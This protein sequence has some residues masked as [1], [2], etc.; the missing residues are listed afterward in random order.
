MNRRERDVLIAQL[1]AA[2]TQIDAT[3]AVLGVPLEGEEPAESGKCQH[4][5]DK[6]IDLSTFGDEKY[7]CGE[8]GIESTTNPIPTEG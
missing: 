4:P 3:L 1:W 7:K 8:C 2:R 6:L 5:A